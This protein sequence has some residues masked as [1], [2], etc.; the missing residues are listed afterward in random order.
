VALSASAKVRIQASYCM[1][2]KIFDGMA[3]RLS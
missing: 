2:S 1:Y 3:I